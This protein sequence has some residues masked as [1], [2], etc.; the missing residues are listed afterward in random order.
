VFCPSKDYS[1]ICFGFGTSVALLIGVEGFWV[2]YIFLIGYNGSLITACRVFLS[3]D[4][5]ADFFSMLF[6][7][8]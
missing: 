1:S 5:V 7:L 3:V 6:L 8:F 2:S 4:L